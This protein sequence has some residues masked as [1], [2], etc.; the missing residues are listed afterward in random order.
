MADP[1]TLEEAKK[2]LEIQHA[3]DDDMIQ[4]MLDAAIDYV[5]TESGKNLSEK[6]VRQEAGAFG[7][8]VRLFRGPIQS[9]ERVEYDPVGGGAPLEFTGHRFLNGR[10]LTA[11]GHRFP[12]A[13][14]VRVSY[15]AGFKPGEMPPALGHAVK[16]LLG[17]FYANREAVNVGNIVSEFPHGVASILRSHRKKSL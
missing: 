10:L 4:S 3:A 15:I 9:I 7:R 1:I 2:H 11:A 5:E 13:S 16:L 17:H 12:P 8:Q 6:L 14:A